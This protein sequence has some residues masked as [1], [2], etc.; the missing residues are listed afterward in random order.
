METATQTYSMTCTCGHK[1]SVDAKSR[2]EAVEKIK[3]LMDEDTL[4]MHMEERHQGELALTK[5]E[6]DEL[7]EELTTEE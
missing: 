6:A 1:L 7:I 2:D 5:R 4:E 3:G